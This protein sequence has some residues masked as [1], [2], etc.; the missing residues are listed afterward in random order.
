MGYIAVR[1]NTT[2]YRTG[3]LN[4]QKRPHWTPKIRGGVRIRLGCF[5]V[6]CGRVY[7]TPRLYRDFRAQLLAGIVYLGH[8]YTGESGKFRPLIFLGPV[9]YG[10][11]RRGVLSDPYIG[12]SLNQL[13]D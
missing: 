6:R 3:P 4:P 12:L 11:V 10:A 8:L 9:W 13:S 2:P 1:P 5:G 7:F